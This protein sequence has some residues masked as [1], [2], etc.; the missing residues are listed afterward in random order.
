MVRTCARELLHQRA[1]DSYHG[2]STCFPSSLSIQFI[3]RSMVVLGISA[4]SKD[5]WHAR[6]KIHALVIP[7]QQSEII[8]T[9]AQSTQHSSLPVVLFIILQVV[10][11][12]T[13][14]SWYCTS[15]SCG[16]G[17]V[18]STTLTSWLARWRAV[19]TPYVPWQCGPLNTN[20]VGR[21]WLFR[22]SNLQNS[23]IAISRAISL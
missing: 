8:R 1:S 10:W 2:C 6:M 7:N 20:T 12:K 18:N 3:I 5:K 17:R 15:G 4:K 21:W 11:L 16:E 22:G 19:Q 14:S 13:C 9:S 23:A